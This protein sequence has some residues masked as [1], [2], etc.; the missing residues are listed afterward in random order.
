MAI[1][2]EQVR[3]LR[4][5]TGAGMM[6]CKR[7]LEASGGDSEKAIEFLRQHGLAA[8]A[9]REGR[10][11]AEGIIAS[12]VHAGGKIAVLVELNCETD[13]VARTPDFQALARELA[14]QV[15]A[16]DP[17]YVRREEV[18]A[19]VIEK[20]REIYRA[21]ALQEGKPEKVVDRIVD[22]RL[23]KFY[24]DFCLLEQAYVRDPERNIQALVT[25]LGGKVGENM[26]VRRFV[27]FQVGH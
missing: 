12:Y 13:F 5:K 8:A 16:S 14:M 6:D 17:R 22:G 2:A 4:E 15:A 11:T 18:P 26:T 9:R 27:R 3:D 1:T 20:E 24:Q 7:A 25:E 19:E 10:A 21:Q 23:E